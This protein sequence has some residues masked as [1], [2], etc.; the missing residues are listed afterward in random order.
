MNVA[1]SI[2]ERAAALRK[3]IEHHSHQY[4]VLDNP[5]IPDAD[6]D[7]MF[8]ELQALEAAHPELVTPD[9]P[10]HR[11]GGAPLAE[12]EQVR[13]L[14]AMLSLR[15]ALNRDEALAFFSS[16]QQQ[17]GRST[18][19][20]CGELKFDG[21][22]DSLVYLDGLL[23][24]A[25]TRGDGVVGENVTAQVRT[26]RNVPLNLR[27]KFP[28]GGVPAR[29][30]VRGEIVMPKAELARLNELRRAA[31]EKE[32]QNCRNA[33]AGSVRQLDPAVTASRRLTFYAYGI[34]ECGDLEL[35]DTHTGQLALLKSL[36]FAVSEETTVVHDFDG[37]DAFFQSV[38]E[39]RD[40]L[41]FDIDGIVFKLNNVEDQKRLGWVSRTPRWA[42][43]YKFPAQEASTR[44]LAIDIQI[45]RTGA[46]TPV[47]RLEP[48]F[49]GGA[50]V[51]NATLHNLDEIRRKDLRIGDHVVIRRAG[52]VIPEIV[53][54]IE[55]R[56]DGTEQVFEMP[57]ACPVCTSPLHREEDKA[58]YHCT[59]GMSCRA[60]RANGLAHYASRLAMDIDGLGDATVELLLEH[61]LIASG[62]SDLYHLSVDRL[63]QLPRYAKKS[64]QNLADAI[65]ATR[66]P[67]LHRFIYAL[68]IP[69]VGENTAKSLARVFKTWAAFKL[70][71]Q[72]QLM[73]IDDIGEVT[74]SN[75]LG[76][77]H[78]PVNVE[79]LA[80]LEAVVAPQD[81]ELAAA[82]EGV[83]WTGKRFVVTGTLSV[84][85]EEIKAEIERHGG[86]VSDSVSKQTYAVI[87]GDAAGTKLDKARALN[88]PV[89]D[90]ARFRAEL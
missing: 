61:D 77:L 81:A 86:K 46:A 15:D 60:Q 9:S 17:L 30:E 72:E 21:L 44:L 29:F 28:A 8:R 73:D 50:T 87:A 89:W 43:A 63:M 2:S 38:G 54:S 59:G 34:G 58:A 84:P 13:H 20:L 56:R 27:D 76:F 69:T 51:S 19:E 85:R 18:V 45:G 70:A 80:R 24:Q 39:K 41:P 35:P 47:A 14:I 79:E 40:A 25:G 26:I 62:A 6:Y 53:K 4:H 10:S 31:G 55:E 49:V 1:V 67:E 66:T 65:A 78:A 83:D 12:F 36:G 16:L 11:V 37:L 5:S 68:G 75:I 52:D 64:A 3:D 32:F 48:V 71:T 90:E 88:I 74:T 23:V 7:Q 82:A 22:S 57:D 42:I 33:A